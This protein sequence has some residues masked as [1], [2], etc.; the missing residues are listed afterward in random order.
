MKTVPLGVFHDGF[1]SKNPG[2]VAGCFV[3]KMKFRVTILPLVVGLP[4]Q[5]R[6]THVVGGSNHGPIPEL[7]VRSA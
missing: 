7:I 6:R 4:S 5:T 2:K 3:V 1:D